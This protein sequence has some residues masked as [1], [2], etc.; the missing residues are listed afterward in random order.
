MPLSLTR[1]FTQISSS[2]YSPHM[3]ITPTQAQVCM[4]RTCSIDGEIWCRFQLGADLIWRVGWSTFVSKAIQLLKSIL[5]NANDI[6]GQRSN[7]CREEMKRFGLD[8][9][10]CIWFHTHVDKCNTC[11]TPTNVT[12]LGHQSCWDTAYISLPQLWY[13]AQLSCY[14]SALLSCIL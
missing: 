2:Q 7:R 5:V 1:L 6:C 11:A 8:V 3:C 12:S 9:L 14:I 13:L 4:L 10:P